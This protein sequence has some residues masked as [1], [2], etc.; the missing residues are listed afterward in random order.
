VVE[1]QVR[2]SYCGAAVPTIVMWAVGDVCPR[3]GTAAE[4]ARPR[5]GKAAGARA[6]SRA[7]DTQALSEILVVR[8]IEA[9]NAR[10]LDELL[11]CLAD[12]VDLE[13]LR[14]G[15]L[16][17]RYRGHDGVRDWFAQ[18]RLWRHEHRIALSEVHAVDEVTVIASGSLSLHG[19]AGIAPFCGLHR[20]EQ[21]LI[22]DVRE[23]LTEPEMIERL[24]VLRSW[25]G[26]A[27]R[28]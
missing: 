6:E 12:D 16:E 27:A 11:S 24:G 28:T 13:P 26:T 1:A 8:S 18:L 4:P 2:C 25:R 20:I 21:G 14:L 23:Y 22:V 10:D 19:D 15:G 5:A 7:P 3:C 9:F 17:R